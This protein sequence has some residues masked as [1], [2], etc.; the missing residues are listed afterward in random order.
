MNHKIRFDH[1]LTMNITFKNETYSFPVRMTEA[2]Y[3]TM[4]SVESDAAP[5]EFEDGS[6]LE[7]IQKGRIVEPYE[8]YVD[9]SCQSAVE[10]CPVNYPPTYDDIDKD[11]GPGESRTY[12]QNVSQVDMGDW[13][14]MITLV[15]TADVYRWYDTYDVCESTPESFGPYSYNIHMYMVCIFYYKGQM[16]LE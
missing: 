6:S 3:S 10:G 14:S 13:Y 16:I 15:P 4:I 12:L 7:L 8:K 9:V 11:W 5:P 1:S 2:T